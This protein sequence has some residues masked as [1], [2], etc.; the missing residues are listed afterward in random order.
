MQ[1]NHDDG[2]DDDNKVPV[3]HTYDVVV[4]RNHDVV[5]VH[6]DDVVVRNTF[7]L[8]LYNLFNIYILLNFFFN[9]YFY[10]L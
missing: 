2:D 1:Y 5:V 10:I 7:Y 6:N 9:N 8:N 4:R 3:V